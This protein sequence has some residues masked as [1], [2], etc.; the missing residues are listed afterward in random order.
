MLN[1]E[2]L[3][4]D[5]RSQI[6]AIIA[7]LSLNEGDDREVSCT[8]HEEEEWYLTGFSAHQ[9]IAMTPLVRDLCISLK[10]LP[11]FEY[12]DA[13]LLFVVGE[14]NCPG[15]LLH[16]DCGKLDIS[17]DP[18]QDPASLIA[19]SLFRIADIPGAGLKTY[20]IAQTLH[21]ET[22]IAEVRATSP[23]QAAELFAFFA[24]PNENPDDII[25]AID[26][27]SISCPDAEWKKGTS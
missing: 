20:I 13:E 9:E 24:G 19:D 27:I 10:K 1:Q 5:L 14:D 11:L 16:S 12:L 26:G 21:H 7:A 15:L 6:N 4:K 22:S 8:P 2:A 25:A 23:R 17:F 3:I 18:D